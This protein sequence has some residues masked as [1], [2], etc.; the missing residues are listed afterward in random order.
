MI[1]K[2]LGVF[3]LSLVMAVTMTQ[4][5]TLTADA[6]TAPD[7]LWVASSEANGLPTQIDVFKKQIRTGGSQWN[8]T[9]SYIYQICLPGKTSEENQLDTSNCFLSWD[10]DTQVTIGDGDEVY[11]SGECPI[12][13]P[14][15]DNTT[16]TY[17]FKDGNQTLATL[18]IVTY[19]GSANVVPVFIDIDETAGTI[20][21]M[22]ADKNNTC[23]GDIYINGQ[24]YTLSKMK[25]R[26]NATWDNAVDKK[27]YNITLGSKINFPG[28]D[29]K[30]TK[31]WS[32]LAEV[33]D[34]SLLCNRSGYHLAHEM[35]I[36]QDTASADVWMNGEYQGCYT[37]TPKTDSFVAD[38]GYMIEQDNY[39]EPTVANGG[40][41]QF[42][43]I[44]LNSH[45]ESSTWSSSYNLISV[46]KMGDAF[47]GTNAAGEVD[48]S[49]EN[50]E[51]KAGEI[52]SWLQ[53]AWDAVRSSDGYND[54][55]KYYTDYI[56]IESFAKMYL[57]HEYIKSYD[58]CAGSILFHRDGTTDAYKLIAGPLWDLDNAMGSTYSN[59]YLGDVSDRKSAQG[60]F[61]QNISNYRNYGEEYKTSIY[62]TISKHDDFMEEVKYQYNKNK[63]Y[64]D[65]LE[66]DVDGMIS[67]IG[68]SAVMN[69]NKVEDI[70]NNQGKNN[71]YYSSQQT[72]G[73]GDYAQT[74]VKTDNWADYAANL[75]TY[76]KYRSKWFASETDGY[77][78]PDFVDPATCDHQY[79]ANVTQE[80]TCTAPGSVTYTCSICRDS[81]TKEIPKIA[82][83]YQ[84]G[85]CTVCNEPL[86]TVDIAC[87]EGASVTVY[88]T[89][90]T[91]SAS[92][93]NATSANPRDGD[94]GL[95]DCSGEGQ[96]NFVVNLSPG[97]E[98]ESVTAAPKNYNKLKTPADTGIENGYRFTRVSGAFTITV[99]AHCTH[100]SMTPYPAAEATCTAAGHSAYWACGT[101]NKYFSDANGENEIEEGSWVIDA[102]GHT[103]ETMPEKEATCTK[104][105]LTAGVK[106]SVCGEILTAQEEIPA[107]GHDMQYHAAVTES[108]TEPG[109]NEYWSCDRCS[110]YF[111]DENGENAIEKDSWVIDAAGHKE[112]K[113]P[114]VAATCTK[115]GLT[116]GAKCSVCGEILTAQKKTPAL[117]H[118]WK[119]SY[120]ID[121]EPTVTSAGSKSIHCSVCGAIKAGSTMAIA[122]LDPAGEGAPIAE[123]EKAIMKAATDEG[124]AGTKYAPLK[125]RSTKQTKKLVTIKWT[126]AK[127]AKKY[128]IYGNKCGKTRKMKRLASVSAKTLKRTFKKVAGKKVKKGTYYKFIIVAVDKDNKVVSTSKVIHV[129]TKGGKV[130]NYKRV[131]V[132]KKV[133]TKA[134]NLKKGSSLRLNA[135]AVKAS[136]LKV[137][138]HR[139]MRY[140]STN[141]KIA[142]VSKKGIV[143]AKKKGTCYVYAYA[144]NGVYKKIKVVVR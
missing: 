128:V 117:G 137:K 80:A 131:T 56:D 78:D 76:I 4:A 140:L 102:T 143:K 118:K 19:Q 124:P 90:E 44:G 17:Y 101:C 14:N 41:P 135:K 22:K 39:K 105:G 64:F 89:Q 93:E 51:A 95:I 12:P 9:Y 70:G 79:E 30:K 86:I 11:N 5:F 7:N 43:L 68:A 110:K 69:H 126:K 25:G 132:K 74:Y 120:T 13:A 48:E 123:A 55:D 31:K 115:T 23:S 3:I 94:T 82:H 134:K 49:V 61:I 139:G 1:L 113:L 10:G 104:P 57:M 111:S 109:S 38:D 29:S 84:N 66:N 37:V 71:H 99:K 21:N 119:S 144:Q 116:A 142:S 129:A 50:M 127:G 32:I 35:G 136:K 97:Y 62:K 81:Y 15:A 59:S 125:V 42:S 45:V 27:P 47:L 53:E 108:C 88:E 98:L 77:Y 96:I 26:G 107:L 114:A 138:M 24:Q 92:V 106:C 16:T 18:D 46:K 33:L 20:A 67:N 103:E 141:K 58:V 54:K 6:A 91:S 65:N 122:K 100:N 63:S 34:R 130:G 36:G 28:I 40:D 8:P 85:A 112:T 133:L 121:K 60:S 52:K 83:D 72:L 87:D 75:K 73:S 2:R